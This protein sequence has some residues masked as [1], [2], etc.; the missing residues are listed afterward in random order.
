[1][2]NLLNQ[3]QTL[4]K[5]KRLE[6]VQHIEKSIMVRKRTARHIGGRTVIH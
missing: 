1:M 5:I 4:I 2:L 6:K 3:A